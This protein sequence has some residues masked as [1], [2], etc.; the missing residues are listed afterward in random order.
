MRCIASH[1]ATRWRVPENRNGR[2][3]ANCG[4]SRY[5]CSC[6]Q[7]RCA[8]ELRRGAAA[9]TDGARKRIP[10]TCVSVAWMPSVA[11]G[12]RMRAWNAS[13]IFIS[14]K[15]A[16]PGEEIRGK[17]DAVALRPLAI[18]A[19]ALA[20]QA[21]GGILGH[22][23]DEHLDAIVER[24]ASDERARIDREEGLAD[25]RGL[26][27]LGEEA[28]RFEAVGGTGKRAHE[29]LNGEREH[30]ALHAAGGK[31]A[32]VERRLRGGRGAALAIERPSFRDA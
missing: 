30:R 3:K 7:A 24:L 11:K 27:F 16:D 4:S 23:V 12:V 22:R 6:T 9:E 10:V 26:A 29:K 19:A 8:I 2:S 15:C 1:T 28:V 17:R 31:H 14:G 18:L 25:S 32:A 5:A 20:R 21:H 13:G